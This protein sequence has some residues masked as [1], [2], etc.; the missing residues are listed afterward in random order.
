[1]T[2]SAFS[3]T[4]QLSLFLF[5]TK[6]KVLY[7]PVWSTLNIVIKISSS[8]FLSLWFLILTDFWIWQYRLPF[9]SS[10]HHF[11]HISI[12]FLLTI[13]FLSPSQGEL[14]LIFL[15]TKPLLPIWLKMHS[16][17]HPH[18]LVPNRTE[19]LFHPYA[20]LSNCDNDL[21]LSLLWQMSLTVYF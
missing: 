10:S 19:H 7:S 11:C 18:V 15:L 20:F 1:M 2:C 21:S 5:P 16:L 4:T 6:N 9:L 8:L 14:E 3:L 17:L 12:P 13:T